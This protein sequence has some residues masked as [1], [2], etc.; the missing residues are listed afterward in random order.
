[1][2]NQ[3]RSGRFLWVLLLG[4]SA[5]PAVQAEIIVQRAAPPDTLA[6]YYGGVLAPVPAGPGS[7]VPYAPNRFR[8]AGSP[9]YNVSGFAVAVPIV[10]PNA[11]WYAGGA[12]NRNQPVDRSMV[13]R[14]YVNDR[15]LSRARAYSMDLYKQ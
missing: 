15:N 3:K 1:M 7:H 6:E 8:P 14:F 12:Y 9:V 5:L 11:S 2:M 4:L 10:V 13:D